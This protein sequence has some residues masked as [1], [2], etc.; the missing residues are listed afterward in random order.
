M[1]KRAFLI[2]DEPNSLRLLRFLLE[3]ECPEIDVAGAF[4]DAE[5]GLEAVLK[6]PP[7]LLFLDI[8]MPHL[9]GF[10]LL[11]R[12]PLP[13]AFA[14][15][16][17]TAYDRYAVRAFKYSAID[18]LLKPV[19]R[20]DLRLA[21]EK[22][23]GGPKMEPQQLEIFKNQIAPNAPPPT[24]L[25]VSTLE[26]LT[27]LPVEEIVHCDSEGAYTRIFLASDAPM[28][29]SKSIKEIEEML[30]FGPFFRAHH[31]HLV[32]L[33]HVRKFLRQDANEAVM[34]NG[35]RIPIAR[36]RKQEFIE[37]VSRV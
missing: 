12:C 17:T 13:L 7:D 11:D 6:S 26:G 37:A 18:Y 31:S 8:E 19:A 1:K 29:V 14:L 33:R 5:M 35:Q 15:I 21:V 16:F 2:D 9:N 24:R 25:T 20:E 32:N 23:L 4:D 10:E 36:N 28:L 30:A 3:K 27:F 22:A 34:S